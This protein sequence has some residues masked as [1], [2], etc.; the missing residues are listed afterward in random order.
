[1]WGAPFAP[2]SRPQIDAIVRNWLP[3]CMTPPL[4]PPGSHLKTKRRRRARR[5]V[6]PRPGQVVASVAATATRV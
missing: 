1:M 5:G 3:V 6:K 2:G 4:C